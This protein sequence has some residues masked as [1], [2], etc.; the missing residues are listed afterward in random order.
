MFRSIPMMCLAV[1]TLGLATVASAPLPVRAESP[2]YAGPGP[3]VP[4]AAVDSMLVVVELRQPESVEFDRDVAAK[5][6]S[7][8]E[9]RQAMAQVFQSR[10]ATTIR[11]KESEIDALKA[12]VDQAK[13]E[14][15][16]PLK[17]ELERARD[18]AEVEKKLLERREQ[19]RGKDVDFAR[20]EVEYH[21]A[22]MTARER[23]LE[24]AH[25]RARRAELQRDVTT[26]DEREAAWQLDEQIRETEGRT[27]EALRKSA[28]KGKDLAGQSV[29]LYKSRTK[30]WE[31]QRDLIRSVGRPD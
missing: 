28:D 8:A 10:A 25:L 31:A 19:L 26:P 17:Q 15:N 6:H 2:R 22:E 11:I 16:E 1:A 5:R 23:E 14:R 13:A 24:L 9:T 4:D 30:V 20:A 7:A 3:Y 21:A 27:L 12:R 18:V 29:G